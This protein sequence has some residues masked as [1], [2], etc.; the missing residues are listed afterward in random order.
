MIGAGRE[1]VL[2]KKGGDFLSSFLTGDID[3]SG[4]IDDME[5]F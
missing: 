2:R 5:F 1:S 4:A 3:H